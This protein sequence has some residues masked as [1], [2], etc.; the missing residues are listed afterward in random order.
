[1]NISNAVCNLQFTSFGNDNKVL[2]YW[3]KL[4]SEKI[5]VNKFYFR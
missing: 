3:G 1:M 2:K 5:I 4:A